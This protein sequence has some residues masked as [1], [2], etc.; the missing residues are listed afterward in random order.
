MNPYTANIGEYDYPRSDGILCFQFGIT[1]TDTRYDARMY[2]IL[3]HLFIREPSLWLDAN[4]YLRA[5]LTEI[6][7]ELLPLGYDIALFQHPYRRNALEEA[8]AMIEY[9]LE[10]TRRVFEFIKAYEPVL[11]RV[12]LYETGVIARAFNSDVAAFNELW[13]RLVQRY[14][15]RDQLT[16]PIA[17]DTVR[18][19]V[20]IIRGNV[21]CHEWFEFNPHRLNRVEQ[22]RGTVKLNP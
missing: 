11:Q 14:S 21:R 3:A 13:W 7:H 12:P 18:L 20:H 19:K 10:D 5:P 8:C 6:A 22:H 2:K 15:V 16:L 17:L 1:G 4:I 9:Q